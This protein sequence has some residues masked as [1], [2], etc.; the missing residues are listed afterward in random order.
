MVLDKEFQNNS[1]TYILFHEKNNIQ[2]QYGTNHWIPFTEYEVNAQAKFESNFMTHFIKGK[3]KKEATT[4]DLL[5]LLVNLNS[6]QVLMR[7]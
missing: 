4:T 3:I 7:C 2:S 1:L 6:F 5:L